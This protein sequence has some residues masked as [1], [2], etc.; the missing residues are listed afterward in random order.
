M[1]LDIW[2]VDSN[3]SI[4]EECLRFILLEHDQSG[5][6]ILERR[7]KKYYLLHGICTYLTF[8]KQGGLLK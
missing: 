2:S 8:V 1:S 6:V 7:S 5:K 4:L 3:C